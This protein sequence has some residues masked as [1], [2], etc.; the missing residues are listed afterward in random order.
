M[1]S[2]KKLYKF[3][4]TFLRVYIIYTYQDDVIRRNLSITH[5]FF[6]LIKQIVT[7]DSSSG[8][9]TSGEYFY[10]CT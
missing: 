4:F 5:F 8:I 10:F 6:F 9:F 2:Q 7:F 1:D 3:H